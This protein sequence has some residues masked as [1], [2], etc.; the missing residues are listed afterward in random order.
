[1]GSA[2]VEDHT[3]SYKL[4]LIIDVIECSGSNRG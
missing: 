1:M 3:K 2:E 4:N